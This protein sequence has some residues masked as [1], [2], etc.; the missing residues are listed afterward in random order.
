RAARAAAAGL[1]EGVRPRSGRRPG[2]GHVSGRH[3]LLPDRAVAAPALRRLWPALPAG[4]ADGVRRPDRSRRLRHTHREYAAVHSAEA[5]L[6]PRHRVGAVCR[7]AGGCHRSVHLLRRG[8]LD[9]ARNV[10]VAVRVRTATG[11]R[12]MLATHTARGYLPGGGSMAVS[13][14]QRKHL[15]ARLLE[16]RTRVVDAL[17][18]YNR[19]TRDTPQQQSG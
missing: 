2:P 7:H 3:R 15:E 11:V 17:A 14:T 10:V 5:R 4:G 12:G 19:A 9:S 8:A 18:R 16:E 6:R 13:P 1:V